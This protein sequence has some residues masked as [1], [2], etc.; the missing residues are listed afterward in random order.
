MVWLPCLQQSQIVNRNQ[1]CV[2]VQQFPRFHRLKAASRVSP[3][4]EV[5]A[6]G[7]A[8]LC[9]GDPTAP[10]PSGATALGSGRSRALAAP[11]RRAD[12]RATR[13]GGGLPCGTPAELSS[14]SRRS[15]RGETQH[16]FRQ[17][18]YSCRSRSRQGCRKGYGKGCARVREVPRGAGRRRGTDCIW[19][20]FNLML[21]ST[22][23]TVRT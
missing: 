19:F 23:R 17:R 8:K 1:V 9:E 5:P 6:K 18:C 12:A 11:R 4:P 7:G 13:A 14:A 10:F 16:A 21:R 3:P 20:P 22:V 2:A 15:L